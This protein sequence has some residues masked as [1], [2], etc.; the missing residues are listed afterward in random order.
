MEPLLE[1]LLPEL[2]TRRRGRL[3]RKHREVLDAI[4]WI[5]RTGGP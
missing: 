4:L 5:L 2:P 1:P 3:W